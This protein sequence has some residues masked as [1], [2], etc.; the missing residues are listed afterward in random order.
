[1]GLVIIDGESGPMVVTKPSGV[2]H[3]VASGKTPLTRR[4]RK[5]VCRDV[6][7]EGRRE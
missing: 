2:D 1:L 3:P 7:V 4:V 6:V 5:V